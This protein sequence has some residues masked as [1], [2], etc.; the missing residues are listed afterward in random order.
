[1]AAQ[2]TAR[3]PKAGQRGGPCPYADELSEGRCG[4][5]AEYWSNPL[6]RFL[7]EEHYGVVMAEYEAQAAEMATR[8]CDD[9]AELMPECRC[10]SSEVGSDWGDLGDPA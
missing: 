1:M 4:E 6:Q 5:I 10:G 8:T 2:Q 9:C 7:C 3:K